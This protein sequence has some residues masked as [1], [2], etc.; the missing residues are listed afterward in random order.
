MDEY[1][2]DQVIYTFKSFN[3]ML[4]YKT[5]SE[6][7]DSAYVANGYRLVMFRGHILGKLFEILPIL[8][9][10]IGVLN[11]HRHLST[12]LLSFPQVLQCALDL[13]LQLG[14]VLLKVFPL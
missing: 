8:E 10:N 6:M 13:G 5:S 2:S 7:L 14:L 1:K 9:F 12:A 11:L 4:Y 3:I